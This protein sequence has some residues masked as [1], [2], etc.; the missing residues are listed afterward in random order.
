MQRQTDRRLLWRAFAY[1]RPYTRKTLGVYATML[2]INVIIILV[3]QLIRG[4]IDQ[5]IY[6]GDLPRLGQAV[7]LLLALTL[8][9]GVFVYYQ[10]KWTEEASQGV[11]YD[12]RN[13]ILTKLDRL[14]FAYHDKTEAGQILSRAMQDVERIRFLTGR[15]VLRLVEGG[16]LLLLTAVTLLWMNATLA[17]LII[18][19]IPLLLHRA[20]R[21]GRRF[22]PLSLEIQEQLGVLTTQL[23]QNLRGARIVKAFAQEANESRRFQAENEK[24][25]NLSAE[26]TRLEA[27]NVPMLDMIANFGTVIIFWYGGWLVVQGQMTLGELVAFTTYLALLIRPI[28]LIGRIIPILAIAA[29]AAERIFAILDAPAEVTDRPDAVDAPRFNG[30]ITF[31]DVSFVYA[32]AKKV[33]R[34]ISFSA[35]PGQ[36]V[37]LMGATGS[38]KSTLINLIARFYDPTGGQIYADGQDVR[39]FTLASL[40]GQIGLVMQDTILFSGTIRDNI[41]FGRPDASEVEMI[42]AAKD[43]QAHDFIAAMPE[44]Y[45]TPVGERGV[46]LSGGQ[47]QRLAIA[48][49]LLTDPRILI[50]DDATA[51]VDSNTERLIQAALDRLMENRTTFVIAHRLST[52]R[53]ADL[54]LVLEQGRIAARGTHEELLV[55]SPLYRQVFALQVEPEAIGPISKMGPI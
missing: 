4:A 22:R 15:A 37:A 47:K 26:S 25:F 33:L 11:A 23:E 1:L 19:T 10:G 34:H 40:R 13:D 54:I 44:G 32:S 3:P 16:T 48:R 9:K 55:S 45:D 12:L 36:V 50:L 42:Q 29:S 30:R 43:A 14:P 7:L 46:T 38:G 18:L 2:I 5:G 8:V 39:Q 6:G 27:L 51:S 31:D 20:Y 41:T 53:R 17:T 21:F 24:W 28:N 52:V 35:E 49:A